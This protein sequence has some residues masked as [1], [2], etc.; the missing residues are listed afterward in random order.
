M[1][2]ASGAFLYARSTVIRRV[3]PSVVVLL[4]VPKC[5]ATGRPATRPAKDPFKQ[6][7]RPHG[8]LKTFLRDFSLTA[9][10]GVFIDL[11]FVS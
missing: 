7:D 2:L 8:N 4:F 6:R 10:P 5:A 3:L 1:S 9:E 11:Y